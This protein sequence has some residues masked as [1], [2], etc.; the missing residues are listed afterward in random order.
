M[1]S[2]R[3]WVYD[4]GGPLTGGM[5]QR[6]CDY[7]PGLYKIFDEILVNAADNKQRDANMDAIEVVIDA[8]E[9]SV[10]VK[11]NGNAVPVQMHADEKVYVPELIFGHLL[12]GS[13]FNDNE[14]KVTGGR[15]G[16]G[17]KLANIFSVRAPPTAR[18]R[19]RAR[20]R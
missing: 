18:A 19:A 10:S 7:V 20:C 8:A 3:L 17:A 5:Q 16:D 4:Q 6:D 9:G 15:N 2:E 12:T 1:I 14:K 11:N 13:N